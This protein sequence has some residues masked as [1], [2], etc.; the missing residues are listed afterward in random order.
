MIEGV[1][2]DLRNIEV[3]VPQGSVLGPSL[4]LIY[5]N[6]LP[7][8]ISSRC[9]YLLMIVFAAWKKFSLLVICTKIAKINV[10]HTFIFVVDGEFEPVVIADL[11]TPPELPDV[12]KPQESVSNS[13]GS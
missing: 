13:D 10:V 12:M 7:V 2:Y 3:G 1:H 4:F 9:F 6:D 11:S 5:I 8:T